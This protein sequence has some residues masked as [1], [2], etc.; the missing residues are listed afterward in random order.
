MKFLVTGGNGYVGTH[1]VADLIKRDHEVIVAS[2]TAAKKLL[3]E[4][5]YKEID[6]LNYNED[7]YKELESPDVLIHLAWEDGFNHNSHTHFDNLPKHL[8]FLKH[9]LVGGLRHVVGM[10]T[11]HEIGF[12][13]GAV[14]EETPTFPQHPY[15]IAKNFLRS[16]QAVLC[17]EYGAVNQW[18]RSFYIVGDDHLNNSIFTKLLAAE[19]AGKKEFPLNSG[20][21]LYD[22]VQVNE[23]A[24]M[25][26]DVAS[27][28][29]VDGIINCCTGDPVSLKTMV[30][31]FIDLHKLH[32]KPKWGEFPLRPYDSRAIWGDIE[33][34]KLARR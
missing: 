33:K 32:I 7:I 13:V 24:A 1:V 22:F 20:E 2:R 6:I 10:G 18:I 30:L 15:G 5:A 17:K 3:P 25:I 16:A 23:L 4:V 28:K 31:Q 11:M 29:E 9:M 12:H 19:Q 27:Q 21:L 8:T 14:T 34:L 26:V